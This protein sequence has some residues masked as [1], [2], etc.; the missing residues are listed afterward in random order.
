MS[1]PEKELS[2]QESLQLIQSMIQAARQE[3]R[4]NGWGWLFWGWMIFLAAISTFFIIEFDAGNVFLPWNIFG[5]CAIVLMVYGLVKPRPKGRVKTYVDD[6]LRYFDI[7]FTICIFLIIFSINVGVKPNYGF[8]YFLMVYGFLM[9]IQSGLLKFRPL[10]TGAMVNWLGAAGIFLNPVFKYDML[11]TAAAVLIG[12]IIPGY[13]LRAKYKR[14]LK[15]PA[16]Y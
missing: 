1:S 16:S 4:D 12:Y 7:G 3:V 5:I 8:G 9:L 6:L 11:I 13:L 14:S 2:G 10:L 15:N